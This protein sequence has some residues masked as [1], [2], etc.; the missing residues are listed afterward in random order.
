MAELPTQIPSQLIAGD[1]FEWVVSLPDYPAP[2][3][4]VTYALVKDGECITFTSLQDGE[5][6]GHLLSFASADTSGYAPGVYSYQASVSN[7]SIRKTFA[8]GSVRILPD[9]AS[10][11]SGYDGRT[12]AKKVLDALEGLIE[13][14]AFKPHSEYQIGGRAMKFKSFKELIEA[15]DTYRSKYLAE[16]RRKA[17]KSAIGSIKVRFV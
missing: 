15:R 16:E 1:S 10:Q 12:H 8:T 2:E 13:S 3:W 9:F 14:Q 4:S 11:S 6:L 17:G 7:G 5:S